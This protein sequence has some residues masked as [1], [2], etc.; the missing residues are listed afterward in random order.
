MKGKLWEAPRLLP[1]RL[2]VWVA[3]GRVTAV[4]LGG[5]GVRLVSWFDG[6]DM[7]VC[8][9]GARGAGDP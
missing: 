4:W 3:M 5:N 7:K 6:A 9:W 8:D 2:I 1:G